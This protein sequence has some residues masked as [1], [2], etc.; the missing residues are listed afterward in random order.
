[1]FRNIALVVA[2]ATAAGCYAEV[3]DGYYGGANLAYVAPGV[4]VVAGYDYPVFYSDNYY[5]MYNNNVWYRSPYYNRGWVYAPPPL[6]VRGIRNPYAYVR[7]HGPY[8]GDRGY[9]ARQYH[10]H[11]RYQGTPYHR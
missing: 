5:W 3:S 2:L 8:Y 10:P 4:S 1:M 7:Y 9:N 6:A 11:Y